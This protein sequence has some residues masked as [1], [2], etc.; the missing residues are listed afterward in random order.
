M[1]SKNSEQKIEN[2]FIPKLVRIEDIKQETNTVKTFKIRFLDE[3]FQNSFNFIPGQFVQIS[4]FGVGEA[5]ISLCSSSF[6]KK[7]IE[8]SV[9]NVGN[10]TNALCESKKGD[11][12]G[13][14]GPYGNGYPMNKLM[15]NDIVMVAGGIG[16][17]PIKS[18]IE[19]ILDKKNDFGKIWLLYGAKNPDD[20][21]FKEELERC[22]KKR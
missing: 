21:V 18:V 1:I 8:I 17:P 11:M 12:I 15:Q 20:I 2:P 22:R 13:I 4:V 6:N 5:P 7:F 14:R 9:R 10:V 19:Y 3:S 16:F